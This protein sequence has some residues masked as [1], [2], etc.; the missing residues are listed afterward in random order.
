MQLAALALG[1]TPLGNNCLP[2]WVTVANIKVSPPADNG[3]AYL[4]E[5][6]D[7]ETLSAVGN[8][9][10]FSNHTTLEDSASTRRTLLTTFREVNCTNGHS[11]AT[12]TDLEYQVRGSDGSWRTASDNATAAQRKT[13]GVRQKLTEAGEDGKWACA[14]AVLGT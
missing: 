8:F 3:V 9:V 12:V 4:K 11:T 5:E 13:I 1:F 2:R 14:N 7:T 10:S 6:I